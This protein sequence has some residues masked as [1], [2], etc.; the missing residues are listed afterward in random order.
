MLNSISWQGYWTMLALV[1]ASYYIV[2][3]LLYFRSVFKLPFNGRRPEAVSFGSREVPSSI[4]SHTQQPTTGSLPEDSVTDQ[5][6]N[7]FVDEVGAYFEEVKRSKVSK[8]QM[9]GSIQKILL[10]YPGLSASSY[11]DMIINMIR[12]EAEH[13]CSLHIT[14]EEVVQVWLGS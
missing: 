7:A 3:Y 2:I 5:Q 12:T 8:E 13:H 6:A 1:L 4:F 9:L 10:K 14:S 11:Q